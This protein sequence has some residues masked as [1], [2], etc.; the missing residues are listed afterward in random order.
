GFEADFTGKA[1]GE[2]KYLGESGGASMCYRVSV[3]AEGQNVNDYH[4]SIRL[5]VDSRYLGA[6]DQRQMSP[7]SLR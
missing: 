3:D 6:S 4:C 7:Y 1:Q 5:S 2:F